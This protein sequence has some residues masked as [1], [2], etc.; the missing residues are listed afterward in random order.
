MVSEYILFQKS[1][2][3]DVEKSFLTAQMSILNSLKKLK[4]YKKSRSQEFTSKIKIKSILGEAYAELTVL[5]KLLPQTSLKTGKEEEIEMIIQEERAPAKKD[6]IE[7]E[8]EKIK[9]RL[10]LLR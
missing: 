10:A 5:N 2:L 3:N 6:S 4:E 7:D 1:E 9:K 8:L